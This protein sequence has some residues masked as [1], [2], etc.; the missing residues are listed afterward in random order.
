MRTCIGCRRC[1]PA[2]E[3]VRV[4]RLSDGELTTGPGMPGRGAWLCAGSL[5]CLAVGKRKGA[6]ARALRAPVSSAAVDRLG[7]LLGWDGAEARE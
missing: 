7:V 4:V 6:F 1:R 3:L 2:S 5:R